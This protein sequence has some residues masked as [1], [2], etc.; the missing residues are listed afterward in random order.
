MSRAVSEKTNLNTKLLCN[1]CIKG[2]TRY[3]CLRRT[4]VCECTVR[5]NCSCV[6]DTGGRFECQCC[7]ICKFITTERLN[8]TR[9]LALRKASKLTYSRVLRTGAYA[10]DTCSKCLQSVLHKHEVYGTGERSPGNKE[11]DGGLHNLFPWISLT[12]RSIEQLHFLVK[13]Y[14][15]RSVSTGANFI[16]KEREAKVLALGRLLT[17]T[18]V[19][20]LW[21]TYIQRRKSK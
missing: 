18:E 6:P 4:S 3:D 9:V 15:V 2:K 7:R 1:E 21:Q 10:P 13:K 17:A 19:N 14:A 11:L 16:R 8:R 5:I 20:D 12:N